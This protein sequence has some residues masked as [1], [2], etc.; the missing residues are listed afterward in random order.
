MYT[1]ILQDVPLHTQDDDM[2]RRHMKQVIKMILKDTFTCYQEVT[3]PPLTHEY[4]KESRRKSICVNLYHLQHPHLF[5]IQTKADT[6]SLYSAMYLISLML[7]NSHSSF[8]IFNPYHVLLPVKL[9][10]HPLQH[11]YVAYF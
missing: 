9:N 11:L 5:T 8:V 2:L 7:Y 3:V 10:N 1:N 6:T 4:A